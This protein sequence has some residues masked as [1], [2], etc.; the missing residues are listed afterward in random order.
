MD[1][2]QIQSVIAACEEGKSDAESNMTFEKLSNVFLAPR[3]Q[4]DRTVK[5]KFL[6]KSDS[7]SQWMCKELGD[8]EPVMASSDAYWDSDEKSEC[9][10]LSPRVKFESYTLGTS[11]SQDQ[12]FKIIEFAPNWRYA[13]SETKVYQ[14]LAFF[15]YV[16]VLWTRNCLNNSL[17]CY[18]IQ[19][20]LFDTFFR[21]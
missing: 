17:V 8:V 21:F 9:P 11:L 3:T 12:L 2:L 6:K 14:L 7:F 5:D 15:S 16:L 19:C 10:I 4:L 20:L 13:C 18:V 1:H